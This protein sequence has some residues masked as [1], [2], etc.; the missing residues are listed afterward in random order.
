MH[1]LCD[2]VELITLLSM[3]KRYFIILSISAVDEQ[4]A[5]TVEQSRLLRGASGSSGDLV[6]PFSTSQPPLQAGS[7][8][9]RSA[10]SF[11]V[12]T[13]DNVPKSPPFR[14]RKF[15]RQLMSLAV[16]SV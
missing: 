13:A 9:S 3:L 12:L 7:P 5:Q 8:N 1:L 2:K 14:Q 10:P 4:N 15:G 6:T 16:L 11:S